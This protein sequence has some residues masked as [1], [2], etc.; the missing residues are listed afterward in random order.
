MKQ[1]IAFIALFSAIVCSINL[2]AQK[3]TVGYGFKIGIN[4]P[5]FKANI[6]VYMDHLQNDNWFYAGV[7]ADVRFSQKFSFQPEIFW[8]R[9]PVILYINNPYAISHEQIDQILLPLLA[10]YHLGKISFYAGPQI[11]FQAKTTVPGYDPVQGVKKDYDYTDSSYK[12][13]G[14]SGVIGIEWVFK[15]RFG[16]DARYIVGFSN[17]RASNG[18]TDLTYPNNQ[19]VKIGGVQAGLF[20]RF[21]KK[22]GTKKDDK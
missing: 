22:Y 5:L 14:F 18:A 17:L 10:K 7:T 2:Y 8:A 3:P 4:Q 21:G 13:I 9:S 6:P 12:K 16:I 1:L 20:F 15:Y 11:S 19:N